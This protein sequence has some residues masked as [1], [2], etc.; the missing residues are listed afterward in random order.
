V[1]LRRTWDK[2]LNKFRDEQSH[3]VRTISSKAN[4][5]AKAL[6]EKIFFTMR[7]AHP[8]LSLAY[9]QLVLEYCEHLTGT[10]PE[11]EFEKIDFLSAWNDK[12]VGTESEK[13]FRTVTS[14]YQQL[15]VTVTSR[16]A[17][18]LKTNEHTAHESEKLSIRKEGS[19]AWKV[20]HTKSVRDNYW[21]IWYLA[22][23]NKLPEL[24][25]IL[26]SPDCVH[27][28]AFDPDHGCTALH[29]TCM[30]G[31]FDAAMLLLEAGANEQVASQCD[32][33]TALHMAAAYGSRELVLELLA[34][35]AQD[36]AT[37]QFGCTPLQLARQ[38]KNTKVAR[39]LENWNYLIPDGEGEGEGEADTIDATP[40]E[41]VATDEDV[42][43][44]MSRPLQVHS[45]F[46][47]LLFIGCYCYL[48]FRSV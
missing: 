48:L 5:K 35:G 20:H 38:N 9:Q 43:S 10:S 32:G 22:K 46:C 23:H 24:L 33:R 14:L 28:D 21:T 40:D 36:S 4:E 11:T 26:Q 7:W 17:N 37:D 2:E 25:R 16:N 18:I 27:I 42:I 6:H 15:A 31:H 3:R 41:L 13:V 39:T 30:R 29:Y 1:K 47:C 8:R 34:C 45:L 12:M 19:I 44:L